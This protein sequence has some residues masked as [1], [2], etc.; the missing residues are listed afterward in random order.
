MRATLESVV[1]L[2]KDL[3]EAMSKDNASFNRLK[4]DGGMVANSWFL[5]KAVKYI[6]C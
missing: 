1:F 6:R 2:T 4:I 5:S 3:L